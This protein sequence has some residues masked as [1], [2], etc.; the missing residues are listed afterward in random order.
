MKT[1]DKVNTKQFTFPVTHSEHSKRRANQWA[2]SEA[3]IQAALNFSES[4]FKQGMIFHVVKSK[5]FP[6]N[7][8]PDLRKKIE[9]LVVV[10]A[11]DSDTI[12]T[13]YKSR[14]AFQDIRKKRDQLKKYTC[15]A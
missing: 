12:I 1:K 8:D 6:D 9:N 3:H 5:L 14:N 2:I 4:F 11:G 7:F 13:C 15:A 10:I